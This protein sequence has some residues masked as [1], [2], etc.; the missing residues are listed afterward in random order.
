MLSVTAF[1]AIYYLRRS[2]GMW[3]SIK[4]LF[5]LSIFAIA[6]ET[7]ALASGF[8]YGAFSYSGKLGPK[9]FGLT[10]I[11]I[12]FS[13]PVLLLGAF[14]LALGLFSKGNWMM[15]SLITS[16]ILLI[17]DLAIDPAAV[18]LGLWAF[19]SGGPYYSVPISNFFGWIISGLFGA[20]LLKQLLENKA[21]KLDPKI[22][23]SLLLTIAYWS[24]V[25]LSI[26]YFVP[27]AIGLFLSLLILRL[28][29][30]S[31]PP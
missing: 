8:P 29:A 2:L 30:Q 13:W 10:P 27:L 16:L 31:Q 21:L 14:S 18:F 22:S 6:L 1:P 23:F 28:L 7:F 17:A 25:N 19:S 11:L 12:I 26:G 20:I 15:H 5:F 4:L 9:L 3:T 24:G